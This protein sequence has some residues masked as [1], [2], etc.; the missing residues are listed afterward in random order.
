M[1][2][3]EM[4]AVLNKETSFL[5]P[6]FGCSYYQECDELNSVPPFLLKFVSLTESFSWKQQHPGAMFLLEAGQCRIKIRQLG[7]RTVAA[8]NQAIV[9]HQQWVLL[10]GDSLFE[11]KPETLLLKF[12]VLDFTADDLVHCQKDYHLRQADVRSVLKTLRVLPNTVWISEL[13]HRAIFER[14]TAGM[15]ASF[16]SMFCRRELIKEAVYKYREM[17]TNEASEAPRKHELSPPLQRILLHIEKH[18]HTSMSLEIL[19]KKA[20]MSE[21][22]LLRMF[23]NELGVTPMKH[24]WTRRLQDARLLLRTGRF[25]VSDVASYVGYAEVS[26]FSQ[27]FSREFGEPPSVKANPRTNYAKHKT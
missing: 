7:S 22:S 8:E 14:I 13:C 11:L 6:G 15:P 17:Q 2:I 12:A 21:S 26:S 1:D 16:A 9:S 20:A 23:R 4:K 5:V 10:P 3:E 27:A 19:C 24:I 18:L 25:R